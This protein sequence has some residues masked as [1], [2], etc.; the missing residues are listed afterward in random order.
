MKPEKFI[1]IIIFLVMILMPMWIKGITNSSWQ[2]EVKRI[3][4][5]CFVLLSIVFFSKIIK[6]PN[7]YPTTVFIGMF[8]LIIYL[9]LVLLSAY[10]NWPRK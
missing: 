9:V 8:F 10:L 2:V 4:I 5:I 3:V 6:T 1:E 7:P